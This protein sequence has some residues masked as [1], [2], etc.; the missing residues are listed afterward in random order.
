M[1]IKK[2]QRGLTPLTSIPPAAAPGNILDSDWIG[3]ELLRR[4]ESEG[5]DAHRICT[6]ANAW[7]ERYGLD[8]LVSFRN[9]KDRDAITRDLSE[10]SRASGLIFQRVFERFLPKQNAERQAPKLIQGTDA[11]PRTTIIAE[12]GCRFGIDFTAGYSAGLFLDQRENRQFVRRVAPRRM[13]NC[14]AYTCSFSVVAAAQGGQTVSIDLSKK[15]LTRGREN[16]GLN[17]L[18][19]AGH[20]FLCDDVLEVLPRFAR[21]GEKFDLVV[22]DPPTFSRSHEGNT[23]QVEKDFEALLAAAIEVTSRPGRVLLST[24]CT[25]LDERALVSMARFGLKMT[26]RSGTFH[27]TPPLPDFP[28][29]G[30][31][32]TVWLIID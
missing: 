8:I 2:N 26:R 28:K 5:T 1:R 6:K 31:A 14:F 19:E 15:S 3:V 32:H 16:F 17:G 27:R 30:G 20:R 4:F 10:W 24:N 29:G 11:P 13:L 21:K 9:E 23:F 7:A 25:A 18:P 22:L 12:R